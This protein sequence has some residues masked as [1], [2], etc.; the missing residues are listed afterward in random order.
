MKHN[1]QNN[2]NKWAVH[3]KVPIDNV[4]AVAHKCWDSLSIKAWNNYKRD[5]REEQHNSKVHTNI[6]PK[7]TLSHFFSKQFSPFLT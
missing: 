6:H 1:E 7:I 5:K 3:F 4:L 2:S